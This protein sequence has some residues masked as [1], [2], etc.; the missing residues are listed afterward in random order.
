MVWYSVM[1]PNYGILLGI[2]IQQNDDR[3]KNPLYIIT[4]K[5]M[6]YRDTAYLKTSIIVIPIFCQKY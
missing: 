6:S 4:R 5:C 2:L 1:D 3:K